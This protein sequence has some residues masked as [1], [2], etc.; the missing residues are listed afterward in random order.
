MSH[1]SCDNGRARCSSVAVMRLSKYTE[2]QSEE[3]MQG[4][5]HY[6]E[7]NEQV[8]LT[9]FSAAEA[10]CSDVSNV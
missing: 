5:D 6:C 3:M 9:V 2:I 10:L 1:D 8:F 4:T 7:R